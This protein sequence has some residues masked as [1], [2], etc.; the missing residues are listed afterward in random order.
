MRFLARTFLFSLL[1]C[2][3]CGRQ[4]SDPELTTVRDSA[5][6]EI[7]ESHGPAWLG[8]TRWLVSDS[9]IID[10]AAG[11]GAAHEFWRVTS[12]LLLSSG[13][14]VVANA[15]TGEIRLF[16]GSGSFLKVVSRQGP[17]P[18]EFR[19]LDNLALLPGDTIA[20]L[21]S[22]A[23]RV[24]VFAPPG[25]FV[26]DIPLQWES[27][28]LPRQM[29]ALAD[30]SFVVSS[31]WSPPAAE[32]LE[33]P[34]TRRIPHHLLRFS[35]SG[36]FIGTIAV[37]DGVEEL[38]IRWEN[39]RVWVVPIMPHVPVEAVH[40]NLM[41]LGDGESFSI[42]VR[43]PS[44]R[45]QRILRRSDVDLRVSQDEMRLAQEAWVRY[46]NPTSDA[47]RIQRE[48]LRLIPSPRKKP[49]YERILVDS[50]R[51]LWVAEYARFEPPTRWSVFNP[52]GILLGTVVVPAHFRVLSIG[53]D[54][55]LGV[56]YGDSGVETVQLHRLTKR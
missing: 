11:T 27:H 22:S 40:G 15:G 17:G 48:L 34:G 28:G 45:L 7:V 19:Q 18:A 49:A 43:D 54:Y 50:E 47:R 6:I 38:L 44:G 39:R 35:P 1:L 26:R 16:D 21:D 25:Q 52:A 10:L 30:G 8:E 37:I 36:Q 46:G 56:R 33:D 51:N 5:G 31:S 41:F 2:Q 29:H 42:E 12:A 55:L 32:E 4:G 20:A 14:F 9:P 53:A 3:G 13:A 23:R 24:S